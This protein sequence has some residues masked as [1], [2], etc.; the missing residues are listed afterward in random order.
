[1]N[2][3]IQILKLEEIIETAYM[4]LTNKLALGNTIAKNESALQLEFGSVL[5][6]I[7]HLY[8]FKS[9][10]KFQLEFET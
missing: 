3:E 10:D 5:N 1:M 2:K 8:E 7:G 9:T 6:S 4:L